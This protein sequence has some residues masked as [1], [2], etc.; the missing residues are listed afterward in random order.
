MKCDAGRIVIVGASAAGCFAALLLARAGHD[1]L[2]VEKDRLELAPDVESAARSAFRTTAPQIVH[3][4]IIL[5]RCRQL[6]IRH[7]PDVYEHL[8]SAGV[9]EAPIATQMPPTLADKA[10]RPGDE[11]LTMLMTRRSTFDWVLRRAVVDQPGVTLR[12]GLAVSG[13]VARPGKPPCV[14][15]VRTTEGDVPADLVV[16]AAGRLSPIDHWLKDIGAR[17]SASSWAECGVAYFSRHYRLR[18]GT[19]PPGS[20]TSRTVEALDEFTIGI[21]GADNGTMQ[22]VVAPLAVDHRFK[23]LRYAEVFTA[24]VRTVPTFAKW[25]DALEPI[26]DV[27]AMGGLHNTLRRLVADGS[28]VA[29]GLAAIGDSVCTTNPTLGRGLAVALSGAVDLLDVIET[30]GD[31]GLAVALAADELVVDHVVPFYEDQAVIDAA[32]LAMLRDHV[33]DAATP[34]ATASAPLDRV[35]FPQLRTAAQFDPTAFRGLWRLMGMIDRPAEIYADPHIVERT[36]DVLRE[37]VGDRS[38]MQPTRAAIVAALE[39]RTAS[40]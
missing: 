15:G 25:L 19:A 33:F 24:V 2:V 18:E 29:T 11:Q 34:H 20:P 8:L 37:H 36:R 12:R 1:V 31:D 4:H 27:Y 35:T 14:T 5:A 26:T 17:A 16:D 32:R 23:T 30:H 22:L 10:P 3:P 13:L 9:M 39:S 40:G 6:L 38:I 7:L 28:P 21:W